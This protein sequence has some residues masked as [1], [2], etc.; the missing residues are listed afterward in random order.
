ML[1][2]I[3]ALLARPAGC[4]GAG[5]HVAATDNREKTLDCGQLG[6]CNLPVV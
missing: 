4:H 2:L 1:E 3:T 5:S 6:Q